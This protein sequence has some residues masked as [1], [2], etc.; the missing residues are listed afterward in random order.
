L[1]EIGMKRSK[2]SL[3]PN[4][5]GRV[6]ARVLAEVTVGSCPNWNTNR[7]SWIEIDSGKL[8]EDGV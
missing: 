7:G 3:R 1:K 6:L 8:C 2:K 5:E 4:P